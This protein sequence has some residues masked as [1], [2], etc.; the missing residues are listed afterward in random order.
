MH[1]MDT[2]TRPPDPQPEDLPREAEAPASQP[3]APTQERPNSMT[4]YRNSPPIDRLSPESPS[5]SSDP[6]TPESDEMG[7]FEKANAGALTRKQTLALPIVAAS[8][9][10][11]AGAKAAR[12]AR[13]TLNRWLQ[14]PDFRAELERAR[15]DAAELA[16]SEVQALALKSV[17]T[18]SAL[19]E[20]P[21]SRV[22][23]SAVR[24]S[25]NLV[26]QIEADRKLQ[27]RLNAMEDVFDLLRSQG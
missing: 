21:D 2:N 8:S 19:L 24:T 18:L 20:D 12:I 1:I 10:L 23:A 22:R 7:R 27:N 3:Q 5:H 25:L 17:S 6:L 14:D 4:N 13:S 9:S 16:F 15:Q 26:R 11:A